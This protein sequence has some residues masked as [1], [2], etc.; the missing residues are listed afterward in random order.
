MEES[1]IPFLQDRQ[2]PYL[3][4]EPLAKHST[5][6]IGGPAKLFCM[7]NSEAQLADLISACT[8]Q[9]TRYYFLGKGSNVLFAD[10]GYDGVV[11][12]LG[13]GFSKIHISHT[14]MTVGASASLSQVCQAA[15][16][17][18]LDGL[19][20]AFGIPGC[21]GGAVY[22]NAGAYGGEIKDVLESVT[23]L[24]EAGTKRV[25][26]AQ[27]LCF[28]YRTSIF[29][30][31]KYCLL[32]ATFR[33]QPNEPAKIK[34]DMDEYARRR[35]EKQPLDM[36][37]AGSTFKRPAGAFAGA[38]IEQCGLR[39]YAVGGAAISTKHCGFVVNTGGATC[40]DVLQLTDDVC[41]KVTAETGYC[42]EK[43][44]R[45]VE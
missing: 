42:L 31:K 12:H 27:E 5:F 7:P 18:G 20:F 11:I 21:V 6:K 39:G 33:L 3:E 37:S 14:Q 45:V 40:A 15:M 26:Q 41:R 32:S 10:A 8:L 43:E 4:H 25:L 9:K 17:A 22:M 38:L 35:A 34:A 30:H 2:I 36:P 29:E 19:A 13:D 16:R 24:D 1:L 28:G 23:V 44:I